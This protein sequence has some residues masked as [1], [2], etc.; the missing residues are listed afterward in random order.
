MYNMNHIGVRSGNNWR[1]WCVH[2]LPGLE[3]PNEQ[4]I[5]SIYLEYSPSP[6]LTSA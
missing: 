3:K 6:W 2:F 5:F 1:D 4:A